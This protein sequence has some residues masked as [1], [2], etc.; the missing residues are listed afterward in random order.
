MAAEVTRA[1]YVRF[2]AERDM[3]AREARE[4]EER[5]ERE[6]ADMGDDAGEGDGGSTGGA[7]EPSGMAGPA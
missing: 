3:L 4:R 1:W 5:E 2:Q 7:D 6:L